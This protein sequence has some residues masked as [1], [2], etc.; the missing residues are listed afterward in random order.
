MAL[1]AAAV[2]MGIAGLVTSSQVG[3]PPPPRATAQPPATSPP[4]MASVSTVMVSGE[5]LTGQP[6]TAVERQLRK[7]GLIVRVVWRTSDAQAP[8]TILGVQPAGRRPV[9]SLVTVVGAARPAGRR[10]PAGRGARTGSSPAPEPGDGN[11][12]GN[13]AGPGNGNGKAHGAGPGN[14]KANGAGQGNGNDNGNGNAPGDS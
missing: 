12:A 2:V 11:G 14:G 6:V 10:G 7:R 1:P 5:T 4:T 13:G 3:A 9:G 8:G